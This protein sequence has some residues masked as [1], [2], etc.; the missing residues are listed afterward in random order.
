MKC[1]Y[2]S[3]ESYQGLCSEQRDYEQRDHYS[4]NDD[5]L[6]EEYNGRAAEAAA[7]LAVARHNLANVGA[8]STS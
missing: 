8:T 3:L 1:I 2:N 6:A 7:D 4:K 5:E